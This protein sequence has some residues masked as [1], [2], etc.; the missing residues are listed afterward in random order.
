MSALARLLASAGDAGSA[1]SR[2]LAEALAAD[3]EAVIVAVDLEACAAPGG[4]ARDPDKA[5]IVQ[6][7]IAEVAAR[8]LPGQVDA[9][10]AEEREADGV[11]VPAELERVEPGPA[12]LYTR[13]EAT[14]VDPL[15]EI[16]AG[17]AAVHG[18]TDEAVEG[19]PRVDDLV[20]PLAS[21]ILPEGRRPILVGYNG[22]R[23]DAPLLAAEL[24]RAAGRL[25]RD[26]PAR[27]A[28][29]ERVAARV[30]E[31]TWIDPLAIR[32]RAEPGD[33]AGSV[34]RYLGAELQGAHDARADI[35]ATVLVLGAQLGRRRGQQ[36]PA[37]VVRPRGQARGRRGRRARAGDRGAGP[38]YLRQEQGQ[39]RRRRSR[40]RAM[41]AHFRF[42]RGHES[43]AARSPRNPAGGRRRQ[44]LPQCLSSVI[45]NTKT[46][47]ACSPCSRRS[48][49]R[50]RTRSATCR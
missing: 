37:G 36:G 27:A 28:L 20:D 2:A 14:L 40:L 18:I 41:D 4:D 45:P 34:R 29:A 42:P 32:R 49:G 7:A 8:P 47:P 46:T 31:E 38:L 9:A 23:F 1:A 6:V 39:G 21:A 43:A 10:V 33:L 50:T 3:P 48:S 15:C 26:D 11:E 17:S 5:R 19:A 22:A 12:G 13:E 24:R 30:L 25:R 35:A 44:R 16:D